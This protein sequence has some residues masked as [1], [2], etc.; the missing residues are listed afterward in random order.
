MAP[1]LAALASKGL[2]LLYDAV[3]KKGQKFVEEKLGIELKP[4]M[5]D[6]DALKYKQLEFDNEESLRNWALENRKL[7]IEEQR[8]Y[9]DDVAKARHMQEVA[10]GQADVFA[11]RFIYYAAIGILLFSGVYVAAVTFFPIP[12][13]NLR[14]VDT[15]LGFVLGT[16]VSTVVYFFFGSSRQNKDKDA[17]IA[18]AMKELTK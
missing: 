1:I 10:L 15:V 16:L 4:D 14:F 8:I 7:D 13:Q 9:L 11:K 5:T 3:S 12:A 2:N 18:T 17:A 6:E